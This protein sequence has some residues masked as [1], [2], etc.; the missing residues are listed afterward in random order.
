M[1]DLHKGL[2]NIFNQAAYKRLN[3]EVNN[4]NKNV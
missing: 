3:F 1:E 2:S 4:K